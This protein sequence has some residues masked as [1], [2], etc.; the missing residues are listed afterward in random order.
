MTIQNSWYLSF[1][2]C[3]IKDYNSDNGFIWTNYYNVANEKLYIRGCD[4]IHSSDILPLKK[5][6]YSPSKV[7]L[8]NNTYTSTLFHNFDSVDSD[9]NNIKL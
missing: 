4:F 6:N 9:I 2:N 1:V 7:L 3:T 5:R 8:H